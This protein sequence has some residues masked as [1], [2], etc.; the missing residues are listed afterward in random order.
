MLPVVTQKKK[1]APSRTYVASQGSKSLRR[2][3]CRHP[4]RVRWLRLEF[5][6]AVTWA[7]LSACGDPNR[8]LYPPQCPVA[9]LAL[10]VTSASGTS[11]SN[12]QA[13]LSGPRSEAATCTQNVQGTL[14]QCD[15]YFGGIADTY[16]LQVT[17]PGFQ[18][19]NESLTISAVAAVPPCGCPSAKAE[20]PNVILNAAAP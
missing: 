17:A 18:S 14:T 11:V 4:R 3:F 15:F 1:T 9:S 6:L 19:V 5:P 12:V 8:C 16:A 13:T 10:V 7:L 2:L 20:P